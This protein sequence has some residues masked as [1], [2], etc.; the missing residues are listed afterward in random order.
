MNRGA[1]QCIRP[2][3]FCQELVD[4]LEASDGRRR[5]R[6]RDTTPDAIGLE[7]KRELLQAAIAADPEPEA[8]EEWLLARCLAAVGGPSVGAVRAVALEIFADWRLGQA[9]PA[10]QAWLDRGAPSE[11]AV[12]PA[13]PNTSAGR[14]RRSSMGSRMI[15]RPASR[16]NPR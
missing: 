15:I 8:F 4:A 1:D 16:E 14:R 6:K 11:D 13:P 7:I 3:H 9:I 2:A 5:R 10:F 12:K